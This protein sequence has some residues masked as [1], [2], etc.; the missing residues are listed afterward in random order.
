MSARHGTIGDLSDVETPPTSITRFSGANSG[1]VIDF[2]VCDGMEQK[3]LVMNVSRGSFTGEA[4]ISVS[5]LRRGGTITG[6]FGVQCQRG[7]PAFV[8]P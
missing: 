8:A 1:K 5:W 7:D 4:R 6:A 3:P 2:E